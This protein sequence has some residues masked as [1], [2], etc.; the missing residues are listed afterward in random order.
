[1]NRETLPFTQFLLPGNLNDRVVRPSGLEDE[2]L[3]FSLFADGPDHLGR[4]HL[5]EERAVVDLEPAQQWP[6]GGSLPS[7]RQVPWT[8]RSLAHWPQR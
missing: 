5:R 8:A 3:A 7:E 2:D 1:M 4:L 6:E